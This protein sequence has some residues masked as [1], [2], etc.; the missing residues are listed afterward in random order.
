MTLKLGEALGEEAFPYTIQVYNH[1]MNSIA[2]EFILLKKPHWKV[3]LSY[4]L[5]FVTHSFGH[6]VS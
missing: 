4:P 6:F 3:Y 2:L 1:P 5:Q